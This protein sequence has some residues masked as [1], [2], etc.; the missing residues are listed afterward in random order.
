[1][2]FVLK[3]NPLLSLSGQVGCITHLFWGLHPAVLGSFQAFPNSELGCVWGPRPDTG[4]WE[5]TGGS[6]LLQ[7]VS[8]HPLVALQRPRTPSLHFL[9]SFLSHLDALSFRALVMQTVCTGC[10][11]MCVNQHMC[12]CR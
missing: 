10:V 11:Y 9:C 7:A 8:S 4:P 1:M 2:L 6:L 12:V 5:L 3:Q